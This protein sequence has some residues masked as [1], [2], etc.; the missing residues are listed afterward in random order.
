MAYDLPIG[1][2][3]Q[4]NQPQVSLPQQAR[5]QVDLGVIHELLDSERILYKNLLRFFY[6]AEVETVTIKG[7]IK[8]GDKERDS[9]TKTTRLRLLP[10]ESMICPVCNAVY[11]GTDELRFNC[12]KHE[13]PCKT[14]YLHWHPI[15]NSAGFNMVIN[16]ILANTS[17]LISTG[18]YPS[19]FNIE[20][21]AKGISKS[22]GEMILE[23]QYQWTQSGII[24]SRGVRIN[25]VLTCAYNVYAAFSRGVNGKM[26]EEILKDLQKIE[27]EIKNTS[28]AG[29]KRKS[30]LDPTSWF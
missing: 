12:V 25:I 4:E 17:T 23:N 1:R 29:Q 30:L 9:E 19:Y 15:L 21:A 26:L 16:S 27:H 6:S 7:K 2:S 13:P 28:G 8:I 3:P 10:D 5:G 14:K 24:I 22:V 18:N 11:E 20:E